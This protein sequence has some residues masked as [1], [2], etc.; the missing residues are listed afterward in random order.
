MLIGAGDICHS[1]DEMANGYATAAVIE[2]RPNDLVFTAGDNSNESGSDSDYAN[3]VAPTWGV[4][5]DRTHP[6][7]GN[8]DYDSSVTAAPYFAFYPQA[9]GPAGLGWYSYDLAND[10][11]VIVLNGNC[12]YVGGCGAGSEQ[13]LWLESDLAANAG[14]HLIAIWHQP[15]FSSGSKHG[16]DPDYLAFWQDLY[17]A[18]A[19][20][21]ING[22]DHDYERFAP[23]T[24]NGVA[25]PSGIREFVV[26]TGGAQERDFGPIDPNSEVHATGT[27]G[28]L[29]LTL[30]ADSYSWTFIPASGGNFNDSGTD[31]AA[32]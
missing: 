11:H 20:I 5:K 32:N 1:G 26:G 21:V 27:Y 2:A 23:Q 17:A 6:A 14:K 28:V 12:S 10:W 31:P 25:D 22:H 8:H 15:L 30:H 13:E 4:F 18:H 3:C 9:L 16:D 24:P 29:E 7:A 19:S